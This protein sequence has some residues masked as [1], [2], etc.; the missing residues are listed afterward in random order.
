MQTKPSSRRPVFD[1]PS[2]WWRAYAWSVRLLW[3]SVL[4]VWAL[5]A[6]A[7]LTL[8]VWIAPRMLDW[9]SDIEAVASQALDLKV[10]IGNLET[11]SSGWL[12]S[13]K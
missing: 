12:P 13:L 10:S 11:I 8:H 6:M 3:W 1:P 7:A 4:F 5:V 2:R 9:R